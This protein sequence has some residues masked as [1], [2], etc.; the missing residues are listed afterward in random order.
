MKNI[1]IILSILIATG[2]SA[3]AALSW[4][5]PKHLDIIY[6]TVDGK[7]LKL[8]LFLP[9]NVTDP[10][11]MVY[12]HGGGW[13][14]GNKNN[15][16]FGSM[17]RIALGLLESGVAVVSIDYRLI[18]GNNEEGII[19]KDCIIDIKDACRFLVKESS[20]Y[21][22][23][24]RKVALFGDSA[25][26]HIAMVVALTKQNFTP[27]RG[28]AELDAYQAYKVRGCVSLY[29]PSSFRTANASFWT[30][31]GRELDEFDDRVFGTETNVA[32]QEYLRDLVS[33]NIYL[34]ADS[35]PLFVIHGKL[36]TTIPVWHTYGLR[37][38]ANRDDD[39]DF[40]YVIVDNAGHNF[41]SENGNAISPT[42]REIEELAVNK[43]LSFF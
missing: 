5:G 3:L 16:A 12:A 21:K 39:I 42:R 6:K 24:M 32:T 31:G 2:A 17:K 7:E 8:D 20:T 25:G 10:S 41:V 28:A 23:N 19:M 33:P 22:V 4:D 43:I 1:T 34:K 30:R 40:D 9:E 35:P 14:T 11:V 27:F 38:V 26:G 29:G 37:S 15:I 36:D 13:A 18:N